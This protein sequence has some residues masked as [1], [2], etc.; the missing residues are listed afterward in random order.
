MAA[1]CAKG[2]NLR[3]RGRGVAIPAII[4]LVLALIAGGE[5]HEETVSL[6]GMQASSRRAR[7]CDV[8]IDAG[9]GRRVVD[10]L[11]PC[12]G[13]SSGVDAALAG[14]HVAGRGDGVGGSADVSRLHVADVEGAVGAGLAGSR[15]VSRRAGLV[16]GAAARLH[17][18]AVAGKGPGAGGGRGGGI[19]EA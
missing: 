5:G 17:A 11:L 1:D 15:D 4:A 12:Q 6:F 10:A 3:F 18:R 7:L 9:P 13:G 2:R 16:V 8:P 19:L 14:D